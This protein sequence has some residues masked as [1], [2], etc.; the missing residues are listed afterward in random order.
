MPSFIKQAA[1]AGF[2]NAS[3]YDLH[4]PSYPAE[5]VDKLLGALGLIG[6]NGAKVLDL[7]A[8]TGKFT[9]L[10]ARRPEAYEI[11]A[12]EPHAGM[13]QELDK[14]ALKG[15]VTKSG[16]ATSIPLEDESV[17]AII[18]AQAF[19]WFA[20]QETLRELHRVLKPT[21]VLGL[22]WNVE[23]YNAPKSWKPTTL[24]ESKVKNLMWSFD[25]HN[26][27][28]RHEGWKKVFEDQVKSSPLTIQTV[29]PLFSLPLGEESVPFERWLSKQGVWDRYNTL[30][31]IAILEGEDRERVKKTVFDALDGD[32]VE[33]NANGDVAI[34][35][36]TFLAW[37][38]SIPTDTL[39]Q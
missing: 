38:T 30:S 37:T 1:E 11:T 6:A 7:A 24:W 16:T 26:P 25:D 28:F 20:T 3:S 9:E 19:H 32:E 10:L 14:K 36:S 35:G 5:A 8:G 29:D 33:K 22:I 15:V 4:R 31:Q 17:D 2:A 21:G 18:I 34:H 27:R 12:V 23:D 13:L 39:G